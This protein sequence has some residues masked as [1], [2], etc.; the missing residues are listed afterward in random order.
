MS[1]TG[2]ITKRELAAALRVCNRTIDRRIA[3]GELP[4]PDLSFSDG[5]KLWYWPTLEG[6]NIR[7]ELFMENAA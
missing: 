5:T 4:E 1:S 2:T 7:R 6:S 3:R